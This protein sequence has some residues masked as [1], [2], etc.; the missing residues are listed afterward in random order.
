MTRPIQV[1]VAVGAV[2]L[3]IW[4]IAGLAKAG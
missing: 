4:F 2:I 1:L 3:V